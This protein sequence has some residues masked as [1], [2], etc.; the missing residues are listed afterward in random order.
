MTSTHQ[1]RRAR[2]AQRQ[3]DYTRADRRIAAWC[4]VACMGLIAAVVAGWW[5]LVKF[6]AD[7]YD[8]HINRSGIITGCVFGLVI[9]SISVIVLTGFVLATLADQNEHVRNADDAYQDVLD[10]IG[11]EQ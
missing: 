1:L 11:H 8:Q 4:S 7:G 6:G 5:G 10:E 9:A 3:L 2:Q